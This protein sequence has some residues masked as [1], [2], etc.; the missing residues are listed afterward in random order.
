MKKQLGILL[1]ALAVAV[2]FSGASVA[3]NYGYASQT[4]GETQFAGYASSGTAYSGMN[5]LTYLIGSYFLK[6][7]TLAHMV[8]M[9]GYMHGGMMG[10]MFGMPG[11]TTGTV[12]GIV[13]GTATGTTAAE[14]TE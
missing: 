4:A 10:N 9:G 6:L 1:L 12:G 2:G 8:L 7:L 13:P 5:P 11:T 14:G 3:Q